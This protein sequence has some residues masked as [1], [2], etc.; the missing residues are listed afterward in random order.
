MSCSEKFINTSFI[1]MLRRKYDKRINA[2]SFT[3]ILIKD[4]VHGTC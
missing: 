2:L 4:N 3:V 1:K